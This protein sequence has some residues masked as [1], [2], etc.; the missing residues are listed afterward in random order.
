LSQ[1]KRLIGASLVLNRAG[2]GKAV[3]RIVSVA[4]LSRLTRHK[5]FRMMQFIHSFSGPVVVIAL[6]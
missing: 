2:G 6:R 3:G 4:T 1:I 5:Y